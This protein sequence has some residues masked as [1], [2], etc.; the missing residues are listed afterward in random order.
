MGEE[1]IADELNLKLTISVPPRAIETPGNA[2]IARLATS[3]YKAA[4]A[5]RDS[6]LI[7][8]PSIVMLLG[9]MLSYVDRGVLALLSPMILND[10]KMNA[11]AYSEVIS[12]FSFAYMFST[13]IWGSVL[14]R[15]GL[16][17]GMT[18]AAGIWMVSS[19][20]H[21]M[22][23][24]FLGF[25]IARAALGIG[26]GAT[27]PGGFRTAMDSLPPEKQL[28][29]VGVA[30][31]GSSLGSILAPLLITPIALAFGWRRA[32]L[33]TPALALIWVLLW[34]G[35]VN[36][37]TFHTPARSTRLVFPSL[38]E[39]RF[40]SLVASYGLGAMPVGA[41]IYLTPLFLSRDFGL[42][43]AKLGWVL[44]IPPLGIEVGYFFW[45]WIATR[46][47][48]DNPR[49]VWLFTLMAVMA[50]P[51]AAITLFHSAPVAI[52]LLTATLFAAGG[53]VVVTLRTG[54]LA[55]GPDQR[56]MA[57]G[58]S[59]SAFSL[60]VALVLPICGRLFDAHLYGRAFLIIG[61]MPLI[62][63][64]IWWLLPLRR[65]Q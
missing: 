52:A 27:F 12:A 5:A 22:V 49:P 43:Q 7:W 13:P 44:W 14:D 3:P 46:F 4:P 55:Y 38:L 56:A 18:I 31:S 34:R 10:T 37:A 62:G 60:A 9:T 17:L 23:S 6:W 21:S 11:Q 59:S 8:W 53:L 61:V 32:F 47:A 50:L 39:R 20:S 58:I 19:A 54:A 25:A 2:S 57:A 16:R 24:T 41:I 48:R 40:W 29:G 30:Y 63:T 45:G 64:A 26:E 36:T 65:T 28:R 35:T 1:R 42:S 33:V 15:I 51:A